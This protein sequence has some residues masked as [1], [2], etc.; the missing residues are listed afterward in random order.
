MILAISTFLTFDFFKHFISY[1]SYVVGVLLRE[2][3]SGMIFL[4]R[5]IKSI[6]SGLKD[7]I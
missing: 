6:F 2:G 4:L 7:S 3:V 5:E 1:F